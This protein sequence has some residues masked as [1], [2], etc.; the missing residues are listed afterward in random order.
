MDSFLLLVVLFLWHQEIVRFY[1]Q[2]QPA[3]IG[4][5]DQ[6]VLGQGF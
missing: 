4:K 6:S 3:V 2:N 1:I 5:N